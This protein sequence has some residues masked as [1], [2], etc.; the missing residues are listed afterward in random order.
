MAE[1]H[2]C[3]V[4]DKLAQLIRDAQSTARIAR[5]NELNN[6]D[7]EN[8]LRRNNIQIVGLPKKVEGRD[9]TEFVEQWLL[10]TFGKE[11]FTPLYSVERAHRVP[12]RP[13]PPRT[14]LAR[15]LKF[16]DKEIMLRLARECHNIQF[17]AKFAEVKK[18]LQRLQ[19]GP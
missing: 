4:E 13:H 19:S 6:N 10:K 18:R 16:K 8:R 12:P 17:S 14:L 5:A 2:I 15:L 7:I 3:D 9:P 1:G 11:E